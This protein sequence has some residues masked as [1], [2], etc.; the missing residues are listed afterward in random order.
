M[1]KTTKKITWK[2]HIICSAPS[3]DAQVTGKSTADCLENFPVCPKTGGEI[4]D[5][6]R[7]DFIEGSDKLY[8]L[9]LSSEYVKMLD[10]LSSVESKVAQL[11]QAAKKKQ[12]TSS[13]K[14]K[15]EITTTK[16]AG[17]VLPA[18]TEPAQTPTTQKPV[19][20]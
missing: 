9:V 14:K 19:K 17:D 13:T 2:S 16:K 10:N 6:C 11:Q 4:T 1:S 7:T 15:E 20:Q 5:S 3:C 18:T 8:K 12:Q